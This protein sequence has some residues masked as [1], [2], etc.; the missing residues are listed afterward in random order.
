MRRWLLAGAVVVL[1]VAMALGVAL[2]R[3][4]DWLDAN[5]AWLTTQV[6]DALGRPVVYERLSVSAWG[7]VEMLGVRVSE[8]PAWGDGDFL[9]AARVTVRLRFLPL[10]VGQYRIAQV[11]LDAP[12]VTLVRG[13]DGWNVDSLGHRRAPRARQGWGVRRVADATPTP[14]PRDAI[15]PPA[16]LLVIGRVEIENGTV[17]VVDRRDAEP[18]ELV[19]RAVAVEATDVGLLEPIG[20]TIT[21]SLLDAAA[22]NLRLEGTVGPVGNPPAP[23]TMPVDVDAEL[24]PVELV[25]LRR[26]LPELDA[27]LP[28][29]LVV[30]G[31]L[32]LRLGARGAREALAISTD[33]D[34]TGAHVV[35]GALVDKAAGVPLHVE[36]RAMRTGERIVVESASIRCD[37]LEATAKGTV[38]PSEPPHVDL[39]IDTARTSLERLTALVPALRGHDLGGAIEAHVRAVGAVEPAHPPRLEGTLAL[40]DVRVRPPEAP[41]GVAEL[42]TTI[43]LEGDTAT[44]PATRVKVGAGTLTASGMVRDFAAPTGDLRIEADVLPLADVGIPQAGARPDELRGL[45]VDGQLVADGAVRLVVRAAEARV[46]DADLRDVTTTV[47]WQAPT[48]T[49][50]SF[51]ARA[52][53]GTLAGAGTLDLAD[54]AAPHFAVDGSAR[55]LVLAQLAALRG[56]DDGLADRVDGTVDASATLRGVAGPPKVLRKSLAGV[57]RV[58]ARD[59][60]VKGVNLLD[61]VVDGL[62]DLPIVGDLLGKRFREK[63]PALLGAG[64]TRFDRLTASARIAGGAAR[65]DDLV[66]TAPD[67][68][69]TMAGTIG[70]AGNVDAEGTL[71]T[72]KGLTADILASI[73]EARFITNDAGLIAVPFHVTGRLPDVKVKPDPSLLVRALEG[74]LLQHGVEKLLGGG[75]GGGKGKK[76]DGI[77]KDAEKL[78]KGLFGR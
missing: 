35:H 11:V 3:L 55:G 68:T 17:R 4:D 20:V 58:D 46:R 16:A 25:A 65:T 39:Q 69:V 1:L 74:G 50:E 22:P 40:Y 23:D 71:T 42:T 12:S 41:A 34:A 6:S 45:V 36:T 54:R 33:V 64:N 37:E 56:E 24:G 51:G 75:G 28:P 8:D 60:A 70:L 66:L 49:I 29:A 30:E 9:A 26:A 44:L 18:R 53:G 67:Y 76:K 48:A 27:A 57:A 21:A 63:R 13:P 43:R 32:A 14:L 62:G 47:V 2:A 52:F 7:R 77:G 72:G 5:R 59:G 61:G 78:L 19:L 38:T 73:R 15:P 31:P 10:V